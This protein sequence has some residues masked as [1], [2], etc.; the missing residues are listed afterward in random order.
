MALSRPGNMGRSTPEGICP[1]VEIG[2]LKNQRH[3]DRLSLQDSQSDTGPS[4][5][6]TL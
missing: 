4:A 6:L 5:D 3:G 1:V 2:P